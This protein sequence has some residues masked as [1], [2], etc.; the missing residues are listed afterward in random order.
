MASYLRL[1]EVLLFQVEAG[2]PALSDSVAHLM[3]S[4]CLVKCIYI[5]STPTLT[6]IS[7]GLVCRSFS[8]KGW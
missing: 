8:R 6:F 1:V 5:W 2:L 3:V 4:E 7:F